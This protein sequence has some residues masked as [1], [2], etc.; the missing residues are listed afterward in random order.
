VSLGYFIEIVKNFTA[1]L[2]KNTA[3][4]R[5]QRP[6]FFFSFGGKNEG[7]Y[8]WNQIFASPTLSAQMG[9]NAAQLAQAVSGAIG[10]QAEIGVDLDIEECSAMPHFG[11]FV[12]A[13][14][15]QAPWGAPFPLMT[16]CVLL[17]IAAVACSAG[18]PPPPRCGACPAG[19]LPRVRLPPPAY[20]HT[21]PPPFSPR[22][23]GTASAATCYHPLPP[24]TAAAPHATATSLTPITRLPF[25]RLPF[26]RLPLR[27][28]SRP[29]S[30]FPP[31]PSR[32]PHASLT[33][34][35][36]TT[37]A[38]QRAPA[39][40]DGSLTALCTACSGSL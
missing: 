37:A 34:L 24:A 26:T 4:V 13:Y 39:L 12:T 23:C 30:R 35:R 31:L 7:G 27:P 10:Y 36:M 6:T 1:A 33:P 20:C 19:A 2:S 25:T 9:K 40:S 5:N 38:A 8:G 11:T 22:R 18:S 16:W 3:P 14:R 32:F 29:P 17:C 21:P 28:P 15:K